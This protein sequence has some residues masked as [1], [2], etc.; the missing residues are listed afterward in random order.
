MRY[1]GILLIGAM[2]VFTAGCGAII[3]AGAAGA[4]GAGG[5]LYAKGD[6]EATFD[7]PLAK[8]VDA[9]RDAIDDM[10][11]HLI[12]EKDLINE[13]QFICRREDDKKVTVKAISLTADTT[14]LSIRVGVFGDE[15]FS[16]LLYGKI[17]DRLK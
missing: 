14:K 1:L 7:Q 11:L 8:V 13:W 12:D 16:R 5:V 3:L 2:G 4:A 17:R 10:S 6:L 15:D 9:S